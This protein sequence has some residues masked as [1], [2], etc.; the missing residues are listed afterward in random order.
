MS[1]SE[2]P[3]Y[4]APTRSRTYF[5]GVPVV[6]I[7]GSTRTVKVSETPSPVASGPAA[8]W[9]CAVLEDHV[10]QSAEVSMV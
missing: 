10:T 1:E 8:F 3:T 4:G 2:E 9:Y 5:I 6:F 7:F